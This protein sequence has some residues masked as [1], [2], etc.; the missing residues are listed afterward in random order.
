MEYFG[1][2]TWATLSTSLL[3]VLALWV[4]YIFVGMVE[5]FLITPMRLKRIMNRQGVQGPSAHLFVG[6]MPEVI[7]LQKASEEK[8]M[9]TGDYDI[10]ARI[11]PYHIQ[12]CQAYGGVFFKLQISALKTV[13]GIFISP[14]LAMTEDCS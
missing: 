8:D 7:R 2:R 14:Y 13:L 10:V 1:D 11:L 5:K 9:K 12:N 6:N 3:T 4:A